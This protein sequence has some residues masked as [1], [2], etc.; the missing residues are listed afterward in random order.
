MNFLKVIREAAAES[1]IT[2]QCL[3]A[4]T[5]MEF[6][7]EI[8]GKV[9]CMCVE[10]IFS[11]SWTLWEFLNK[12][13]PKLP[14]VDHASARLAAEGVMGLLA[15]STRSAYVNA[16]D[17]AQNEDRIINGYVIF[18]S[19]NFPSDNPVISKNNNYIRTDTRLHLHFFVRTQ[20]WPVYR[21]EALAFWTQASAVCS[22]ASM[23]NSNTRIR[24]SGKQ[25]KA[26]LYLSY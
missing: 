10:N 5:K 21:K 2:W 17:W 13:T 4:F 14:V 16:D 7:A 9:S 15:D 3:S 1:D 20:R 11:S 19:R 12:R 25:T 18:H 26:R 8:Y 23:V 24:T 22:R 6:P